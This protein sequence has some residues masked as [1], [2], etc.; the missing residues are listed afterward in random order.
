MNRVVRVPRLLH[1][2]HGEETTLGDLVVTWVVALGTALVIVL[3]PGTRPVATRWWEIAIVAAIGADIAA[4]V[5]ATFTA[6]TDR[7]YA[8]R[9]RLRIVFLLLHV[10]QPTLLFFIIGGPVEVWAVVP[11]FAIV[12]ALVVNALPGRHQATLAAALT[13]AGVM[14]CFGWFVVAPPALWFGPLFTVK[15]VLGFAVR[16]S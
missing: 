6:G 7:F 3:R 8:A 5:V 4:G 2:L 16:R 10:I 15:L 1:V 13:V 12:S 14:I 9:P 11:A